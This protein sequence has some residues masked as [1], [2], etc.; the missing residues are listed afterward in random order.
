MRKLFMG[1][2]IVCFPAI[3]SCMHGPYNQDWGHGMGYG[4]GGMWL[5]W[6]LIICIIIL[7]AYLLIRETKKKDMGTPQLETPLEILKKRYASG[8]ISKEQFEEMRRDLE[9]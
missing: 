8:D 7:A 1:L 5:M 6:L 9:S 4:Y 2:L 3:I